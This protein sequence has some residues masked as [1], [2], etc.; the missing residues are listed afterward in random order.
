MDIASLWDPFELPPGRC[1]HWQIGPLDLWIRRTALEWHIASSRDPLKEERLKVEND[2]NPGE[3]LNWRRW[4]AGKDQTRVQLTAVMPDRPIIIR[5]DGAFT[6]LPHEEVQFF[7]GI[8]VWISVKAGDN[9]LQEMATLVLT[10]SWFGD[11]TDGELCYGLLTT[12]K[13]T[14][15]DLHNR[16]YRAVCP[17]RIKNSSDENLDFQR[18]CLRTQFLTVFL[19]KNHLW[20]SEGRVTYRGEAKFSRLIYGRNA[21]EFDDAERKIGEARK[22]PE[23]GLWAKSFDGLRSYV[24][25]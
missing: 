6:V 14:P 21:P 17:I 24:D 13:R 8:P 18:L 23:R 5:P 15:E 7:V 12:A 25:L 3:D 10:N 1:T 2:A 4:T 19:G 16:P 20:T 9:E 11:P 22:S